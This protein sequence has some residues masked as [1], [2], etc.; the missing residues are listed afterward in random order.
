MTST[1]LAETQ[2]DPIV[3]D[4]LSQIPNYSNKVSTDHDVHLIR[5]D[6]DQR[7]EKGYSITDLSKM[8]KLSLS[9]ITNIGTRQSYSWL[10]EEVTYVYSQKEING[11]LDYYKSRLDKCNHSGAEELK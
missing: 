6:Y 4:E 11:T 9:A 2:A 3:S 5:A 10:P 8:H 1:P 7:R